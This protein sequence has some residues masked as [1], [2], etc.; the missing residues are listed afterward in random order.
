[1]SLEDVSLYYKCGGKEGSDAAK[2]LICNFKLCCRANL[3][4]AIIQ[5]LGHLI[6]FCSFLE[7]QMRRPRFQSEKSGVLKM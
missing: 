4:S 6:S 5:D 3:R 1:M 7:V 2:Q